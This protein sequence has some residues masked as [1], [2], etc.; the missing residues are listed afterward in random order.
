MKN[1]TYHKYLFLLVFLF[2]G[3]SQAQAQYYGPSRCFYEGDCFRL[4]YEAV[5]QDPLNPD[6]L[7]VVVS[8]TPSTVAACSNVQTFT[9][10]PVGG[11]AITYSRAR[12]LADPIVQLSVDSELFLATPNVLV[13]TV[14]VITIRT[15]FFTFNFPFLSNAIALQAGLDSGDPCVSITPLPV[16]LASFTGAATA[17]GITL[18]WSTA[19]EDNNSH[20]EIE[21]SPDGKAF[22]Q[23]GLVQGHG[24]SSVM[25]YYTHQDKRPK[26]GTNYYRLRQVDF[27]GQFEYSKIIAVNA[28]ESMAQELQVILAPN[29]CQNGDCD[30][31][32][33]NPNQQQEIQLQLQ[34]LSGKV[35]FEQTVTDQNSEL[36]LTKQQLQQLRGMY[37]LSAKA[38]QKTVRQRIILE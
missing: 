23:I 7:I 4:E 11:S 1:F 20:F 3:A 24:N 10:T 13:S 33:L 35:I 32:L 37:L 5:L 9:F 29:P 14:S 36:R 8:A 38:G 30:I 28:S 34:D 19:S 25:L 31:S 2:L 22:E 6:D 17:N 16:E 18:E 21:R 26:P 12:L 27:D 15:P